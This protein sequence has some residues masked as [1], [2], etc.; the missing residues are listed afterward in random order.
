MLEELRIKCPSCGIVLDVRNSRHEAVKRIVCPN[1]QKQLAVDFQEKPLLS[2]DYVE[3]RAVRIADGSIKRILRVKRDGVKLNGQPLQVDDEVVL[4][5][6]DEL[7]MPEPSIPSPSPEPAKGKPAGRSWVWLYALTA[8]V[9]LALAVVY[10][11]PS[12]HEEPVVVQKPDT[13]QKDTAQPKVELPKDRGS[14]KPKPP[15]KVPKTVQD[16]YS[17]KSDYELGLLAGKDD[18][19][20]QFELGKRKISKNDSVSVVMGI[21]YLRLA[22]QNGSS[23]AKAKLHEVYQALQREAASGNATAANIL[24]KQ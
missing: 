14:S 1:C 5:E 4:T 24:N 17:K 10:L 15:T 19:K 6:I 16:D 13:E 21:N 20:A 8:C 3:I 23:D 11:W 22:T 12:R 7:K 18:A 9:I 2:N